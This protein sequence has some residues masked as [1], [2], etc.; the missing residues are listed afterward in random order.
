MHFPAEQSLRCVPFHCHCRQCALC[1]LC[2]DA[3]TCVRSRGSERLLAGRWGNIRSLILGQQCRGKMASE[4]NKDEQKECSCLRV[5]CLSGAGGQKKTWHA[6]SGDTITQCQM[7]CVIWDCTSS[8]RN[9][10]IGRIMLLS[11]WRPP[12]LRTHLVQIPEHQQAPLKLLYTYSVYAFNSAWSK[13]S[14][15][16]TGKFLKWLNFLFAL[17]W[18]K[19]L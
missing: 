6:F 2:D 9:V 4:L 13:I 16:L 15:K 8:R 10:D 19:V 18:K 1:Y 3:L 7:S 17:H 11:H 12:K 14:S 5:S